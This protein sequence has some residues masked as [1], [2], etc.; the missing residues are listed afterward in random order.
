[1]AG[2]D[3]KFVWTSASSGYISKGGD[4]AAGSPT[5]TLLQLHPSHRPRR[6]ERPPKLDNPL[7]VQPT[8]MV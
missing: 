1:M 8:P 2:N 4:P 3:R 7:L 5:A 6:G